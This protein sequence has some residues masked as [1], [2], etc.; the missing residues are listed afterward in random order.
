MFNTVW[1]FIS[2]FYFQIFLF[3]YIQIVYTAYEHC[4]SLEFHWNMTFWHMLPGPFNKYTPGIYCILWKFQHITGL[5]SCGWYSEVY[6]SRCISLLYD[7]TLMST[8]CY[9][10]YTL[11]T[12]YT[13]CWHCHMGFTYTKRIHLV[14]LWYTS[15]HKMVHSVYNMYTSGFIFLGSLYDHRTF[16]LSQT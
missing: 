2:L 6:S 5:I 4:I 3:G 14:Y 15:L 9:C 16:M 10:I 13:L 11:Y 1:L 12:V 8:P 7:C